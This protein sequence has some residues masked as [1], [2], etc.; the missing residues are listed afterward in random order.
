M[1]FRVVD[2]L[3]PFRRNPWLGLGA[4]LVIFAA[5]FLLRYIP[6]NIL[7]AVPFI[8]LFPA[9]LLAALVGGLPAGIM[10]AVF[11]FFA[12]WYFFVPPQNSW[13]LSEPR[14]VAALVMFWVTA[15]IQLFVIEALIRATDRLAEERDRVRVLFTELQHRV[16]NNIA[17][18]S[19][20]LRM[21]RRTI[22]ADASRALPVMEQAEERLRTVAQIHRRLYDPAIIDQ[23]LQ[24]YLEALTSDV[25]EAAG[26]RNV[27][28]SVQVE[29]IQLEL[30]RLVTLSLLLNE[31]MTNSLKHAFD[32]DKPGRIDVTLTRDGDR[33]TLT[34]RDDGKG[35]SQEMPEGSLGLT[36]IRSLASQLGGDIEWTSAGGTTARLVF[37]A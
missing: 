29:Q 26:V 14:A 17:F 3:R 2:R 4:G 18:L 28:C 33:I 7:G 21:Q 31:V 9:I 11:S 24:A 37:R 12:G 27:R 10:V 25:I 5:G 22:E 16:A 30:P 15:A 8:T 1:P 23:P 34:I 13:S 19:A 35:V 20:L 36:I 6:G 32:A